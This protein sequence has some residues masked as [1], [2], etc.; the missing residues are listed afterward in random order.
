MSWPCTAPLCASGDPWLKR[1]TT[2]GPNLGS[3]ICDDLT[4]SS[5]VFCGPGGVL[6]APKRSCHEGLFINDNVAANPETP[7]TFG[8]GF[9]FASSTPSAIPIPANTS[10]CQYQSILLFWDPTSGM[11]LDAGQ[12][13]CYPEW[14]CDAST[15]PVDDRVAKPDWYPPAE[16]PFAA[17]QLLYQW[18]SLDALG[19]PTAG[20]TT[21]LSETIRDGD[22]Y[23]S[24]SHEHFVMMNLRSP[25]APAETI[26]VRVLYANVS[27]TALATV[28]LNNETSL[29]HGRVLLMNYC[30]VDDIYQ[31]NLDSNGDPLPGYPQ[32]TTDT[33]II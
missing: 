29:F 12:T 8:I 1:G 5:P 7:F 25:G 6:S 11:S 17:A 19:T 10:S 32:I 15:I 18:R 9:F 30:G 33:W 16:M 13:P 27:N 22:V 2:I 26:E 23:G 24:N 3:P 21:I 28:V 20:W 4:E 14:P 31:T